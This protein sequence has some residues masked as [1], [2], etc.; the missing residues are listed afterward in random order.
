MNCLLGD[1]TSEVNV[2]GPGKAEAAD[3]GGVDADDD[4][5]ETPTSKKRKIASKK[6]K[7]TSAIKMEDK[8]DD[9]VSKQGLKSPRD[10]RPANSPTAGVSNDIEAW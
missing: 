3:E 1:A 7:G 9:G 5:T 6:Q 4:Q 8:D 2:S 10:T